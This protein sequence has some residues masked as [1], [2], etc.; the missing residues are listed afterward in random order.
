MHVDGALVDL[1][2]HAPHP[3]EELAAGEDPAG[4][5]HQELQQSELGR[6]EMHLAARPAHPPGLA[7]EQKVAG[8]EPARQPLRAG[9]AQQRTHPRHQ[10]GDRERLHHVIVG[11]HREAPDALGLLAPRSQHDDRKGPCRFPSPQAPAEFQAGDPGEHP[12]EDDEVRR[13]F[14]QPQLG[15]VAPLDPL[16]HEAFRLEVVGEQQRERLLV[17]HHHDGGGCGCSAPAA[18][19]SHGHGARA[20][21]KGRQRQSSDAATS[22]KSACGSSGRLAPRPLGRSTGMVLPVTR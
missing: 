18:A 11:A 6:A 9:A 17:L 3:V 12:V 20:F 8:D 21:S 10:L 5:L 14:G 22:P 2:R 19:R 16:H 15:V 7:V 13:R 1:D 4:P